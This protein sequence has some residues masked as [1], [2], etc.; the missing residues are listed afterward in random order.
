MIRPKV[1]GSDV[2]I[3]A[4]G[5]LH[6]YE[7]FVVGFTHAA[8]GSIG[9]SALLTVFHSN[10][11]VCAVLALTVLSATLGQWLIR[12]SPTMRLYFLVPQV[13]MLWITS[14]GAMFAVANGH[15]ADG[16]IRSP[17]F[18]SCDQYQRI[19]APFVYTTAIFFRIGER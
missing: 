15:Y 9:I 19:I 5:I 6:L 11:I 10:A 18:I 1:L 16:V 2:V 4:Y 14:I 13:T 17:W 3:L 12:A 7:A 8:N